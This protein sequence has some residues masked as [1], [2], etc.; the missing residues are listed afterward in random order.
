VFVICKIFSC[1]SIIGWQTVGVTLT[2]LYFL[3]NS[4]MGKLVFYFQERLAMGKHSSLFS[5]F[6]S[7]EENEVL[8]IL[9]LRIYST[10]FIFFITYE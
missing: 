5:P 6:I 8:G 1:L 4:R 3:G 9:P 10:G 2:I 7:Y